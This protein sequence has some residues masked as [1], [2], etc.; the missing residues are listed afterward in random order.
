MNDP[1][2]P[3]QRA[4]TGRGGI[5]LAASLA[6]AAAS[7][8][9][10]QSV[11][12][13]S[14]FSR[15]RAFT[16]DRLDPSLVGATAPRGPAP[17]TDS[18]PENRPLALTGSTV[19]ATPRG[20]LF[21]DSDS[22]Q[23]VYLDRRRRSRARATVGHDAAQLLYEPDNQHALVADRRGDRIAIFHITDRLKHIR[24]IST[25]AEPYG[26]ALTPD[27]QTLLV[28]TIADRQVSA[29]DLAT[30]RERWSL[31]L[32][33]EPRAVAISPDGLRAV[34]TFATQSAIARIDLHQ[35]AADDPG[36]PASSRLH[37][38][39]LVRY[40]PEQSP[41]ATVAAGH[42]F[43]VSAARAPDAGRTYSRASYAAAYLDERVVAVPYQQST[44][45]QRVQRIEF[46]SYGG[47]LLHLPIKHMLAFVADRDTER[48]RAGQSSH[49][50]LGVGQ[51]RALAYDSGRDMLF[52][53]SYNSDRI[54]AL[55]A[56]SRPNSALS[57]AVEIRAQSGTCGPSGLA[58]TDSGDL[59]VHCQIART[60]TVI[61]S[62]DIGN[63]SLGRLG[64]H[65]K[66]G[67]PLTKSRL[68]ASAQRGRILFTQ[69]GNPG[70]SA[71]GAL[72]CIDCHPEGRADGLSWAIHGGRLQTPVLAGRL[73]GT[74]PYKWRGHDLTLGISIDNTIRRLGGDGLGDRDND[75]LVAFLESLPAP[76]A[77]TVSDPA[78]V[79]RGKTT[80]E[81]A[82]CADCHKRPTLADR[83]LH[84]LDT[85]LRYVNTP[86][87]IGASMSAPYFHD[88]SAASL[89]SVLLDNGTVHD[90]AD[91]SD[92]DRQQ[93]DDL[94][95]YLNTL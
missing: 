57:W 28:T 90:M 7:T 23:L 49:A 17:R 27:R 52:L 94:I 36:R 89:R 11:S 16:F 9:V 31:D 92:M 59:L 75:D 12:A 63:G 47:S 74:A 68:S 76:R 42:A 40:Q 44:P 26:L 58:L 13:R 46:G 55:R 64:A 18:R 73:V 45:A 1:T 66:A 43:K 81:D 14:G 69:M 38:A 37:Y 22:G 83:H 2:I 21:I 41:L 15:I 24:D 30:G 72:A 84:E 65:I 93:L 51:I 8:L 56:A 85:N 34:V 33:P 70:I 10:A 60:V 67:R 71:D 4:R 61:A 95:T 29:Y 25:R 87:L 88:G 50:R 79:A 20:A 77:P 86:S 6:V 80:F 3:V 53:A 91:V 54:L 19:A 62:R 32:A 78:A 35:P 48:A 5:A 39:S 82:G